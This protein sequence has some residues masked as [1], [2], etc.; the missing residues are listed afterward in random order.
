[1]RKAHDQVRG[2]RDPVE[3]CAKRMNKPTWRNW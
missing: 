1:L 2:R 3:T